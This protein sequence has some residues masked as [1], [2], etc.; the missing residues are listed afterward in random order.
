MEK[1]RV[2][3][4]G[5][6]PGLA[7]H[8]NALLVNTAYMKTSVNIK[9]CIDKNLYNSVPKEVC[10]DLF[11]STGIVMTP[12]DVKQIKNR[13]YRARKEGVNNSLPCGNNA[14]DN[15]QIVMNMLSTHPFVQQM[16]QV[17]NSAPSVIHWGNAARYEDKCQTSPLKHHWGRSYIQREESLGNHNSIQDSSPC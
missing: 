5:Q 1:A 3:Y 9:A 7:S 17:K 11:E 4:I 8:G 10:K 6:Y 15:I 14:A 12:R 13:K 2:E 16:I